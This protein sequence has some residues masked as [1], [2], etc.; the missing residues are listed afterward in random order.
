MPKFC[1]N[2]HQIEDSWEICPYCQRH[3]FRG[4]ASEAG[5]KTRL[6]INSILQPKASAAAVPAG[7]G[8]RKTVLLGNVVPKGSLVGW[9]VAMDGEHKG[10]DFR[11]RDGQT[12]IGSSSDADIVLRD[13]TISAK[14]ASVRC[15]DGRFLLTD[16]DSTNGTFLNGGQHTI[17]REQLNDNDLIRLGAVTLKFKML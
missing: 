11:I 6:E 5:S 7:V 13:Q 15:K 8:D 3:G 14:H 2:G 12:T 4:P 9:L 17:A 1:S 16:L 10:E